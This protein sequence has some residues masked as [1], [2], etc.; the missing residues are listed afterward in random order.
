MTSL[1]SRVARLLPV[2]ALLAFCPSCDG[3]FVSNNSI[4]TIS[5]SPTAIILAVAPD[6]STPGDN[7]S[8][9][10]S[11]RTVGGTATDATTTATWTSSAPSVA[12]VVAGKV[13]AVTTT[14]GSTATITAQQ[15]GQSGT[16]TVLTYTGNPPAG[17]SVNLPNGLVPTSITPGQVFQLT[18]VATVNNNTSF[19]ISSYVAWTSSVTSAAI[20][21]ANGVVTVLS[22]ATAGTTFTVTATAYLG[23]SATTPTVTG[24]STTFTILGGTLL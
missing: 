14:G 16:A 24:T 12:T 20:V 21:N 15:S 6:A 2:L 10:A 5:V 9:K 19:N 22:T 18:A 3:F 1:L 11:A 13:T 4:Q 23:S 7:Y 8:L 17:L